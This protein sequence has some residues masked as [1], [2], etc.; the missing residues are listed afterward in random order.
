MLQAFGLN[1]HPSHMLGLGQPLCCYAYVMCIFCSVNLP[2]QRA[3]KC[4]CTISVQIGSSVAHPRD[5]QGPSKPYPV[6][7]GAVSLIAWPR[8]GIYPS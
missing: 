5:L 2:A 3:K 1:A 7:R 8:R 6:H 4:S